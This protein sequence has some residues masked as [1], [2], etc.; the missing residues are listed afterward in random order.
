MVVKLSKNE[1]ENNITITIKVSAPLIAELRK[2]DPKLKLI[3]AT[4]I[5]DMLLREKKEQLEKKRESEA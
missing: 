4:Y 5:V 1:T 3:P 2:L